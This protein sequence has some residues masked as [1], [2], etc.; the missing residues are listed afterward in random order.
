MKITTTKMFAGLCLLLCSGCSQVQSFIQI[1]QPQNKTITVETE[2]PKDRE[3]LEIAPELEVKADTVN[4][5]PAKIVQQAIDGDWAIQVVNG[6]TAKGEFP[7]FLKFSPQENYVY[8]NNGCNVINANYSCNP[9]D[10]T[11]RFDNVITTMR[12]CAT[13]GLSDLDINNALRETRYYVIHKEDS[14]QFLEFFDASQHPIMLLMHQDFDFLNGA[15]NVIEIAGQQI[16]NQDMQL[17]FD[18][19]EMKVHGNTGCNI[20]NGSLETD[21]ETANTISFQGIATTRMACPDASNETSLLAAL[22]EVTFVN[23]LPNDKVELLDNRGNIVLLLHRISL[24]QQ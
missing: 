11:L 14:R 10:S 19:A 3:T 9:A 12:A 2:V 23:P 20:L 15:W 7:P 24:S 4:E 21:L 8:G 13:E 16:D 17:V 6:N 5:A 1:F 22:E 18:I